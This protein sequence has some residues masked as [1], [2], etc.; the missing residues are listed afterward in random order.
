MKGYGEP[1]GNQD[2]ADI[3]PVCLEHSAAPTV[4]ASISSLCTL[5]AGAGDVMEI[6][7]AAINKL[8]QPS[9]GRFP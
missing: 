1:L 6:E 2:R 9:R 8:V 4:V 5:R 3:A 7:S